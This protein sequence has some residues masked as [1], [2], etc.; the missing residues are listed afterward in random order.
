VL[1]FTG[2]DQV[3]SGRTTALLVDRTEFAT[4]VK[5]GKT[6]IY[7]TNGAQGPNVTPPQPYS[8]LFRTDDASLLVQGSPNAGLWKKLTSNVNG[9]PFYPTYNFCTEQCWYD[10]DVATPPGSPDTVFVIGSYT[11]R[12][13]GLRSNA[14]AVLRSTTAGEPDPAHNNRTFTDMTWDSQSPPYGIHPDQHELAF[15]PSNPDIWWSTSDGG[16][17]RSSGEYVDASAQC[18]SRPIGAASMLARRASTPVTRRSASTSSSAA[19]A[20]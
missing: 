15:H 13:A 11:Y 8:A 20:T 10:Q 3:T 14:R 19:S 5:D 1:G 4:T 12:E 17:V 6:R 9:D 16:V 2:R 7:V 18:D